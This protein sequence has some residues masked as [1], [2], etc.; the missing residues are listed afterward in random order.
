MHNKPVHLS[1]G[2][3]IGPFLLYGILGGHDHKQLGQLVRGSGDSDLALF[4]GLQ[5]R[6]LDLGWRAVDF[7]C[8][9]NVAENGSLL[10]FEY[11]LI[12]L[13]KEDF[14]TGNV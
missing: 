3:R 14:I 10:E 11:L 2:Q 7:I 6:C 1:L 8:Q 12:T 4:H 13:G 9:D 5:Q